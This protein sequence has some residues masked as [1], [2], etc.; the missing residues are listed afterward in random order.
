[1]TAGY[2]SD[3]RLLWIYGRRDRERNRHAVRGRGGGDFHAAVK[4]PAVT[5]AVTIVGESS[6]L[7]FPR[8][9]RGVFAQSLILAR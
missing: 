3:E 1:V 9:R 7:P 8:N 5:T 6:A 4:E 2:S